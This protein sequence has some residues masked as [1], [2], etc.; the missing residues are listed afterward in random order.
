M[1]KPGFNKNTKE[2]SMNTGEKIKETT[3]KVTRS[4]TFKL[5]AI[6][7]LILLLLIPAYMVK[8]LIR[9]RESRQYEVIREITGK[10]GQEQTITGPVITVPYLIYYKDK[11]GKTISSTRYFHLLPDKVDIKSRI[12]PEVR[13]RSIYEAVLYNTKL[14]ITG[15]FPR[16]PLGKL[17][18]ASD[19]VVWSGASISLG[20]TDMIGIKEGIKAD[21]SGQTLDMAPGLET[22]DLFESGVSSNIRIDKN[23]QSFPFKFVINLNGSSRIRFAPV[24][25]ITTASVTSSWKDPSFDGAFLPV[26]REISDKGFTANWKVLHLNRSYPQCW[27]GKGPSLWESTF[28][29]KLYKP[30]DIYQKSTRMA[31]YALL[32]IVFT[33]MAFFISEIINK[34]RVHPVQYILIGLSILIFY[35]L[36]LSFSEHIGFG[37]AY[38]ISATAIVTMV[39]GY[40]QSVLKNRKVAVMVGGLLAI[41]YTYLYILLQLKDYALL[42]GSIG[43]LAVMASIMYMTRR[44]DWYRVGK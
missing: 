5:M 24:G 27:K 2:S 28:G 41:L 12:T 16:P 33:F 18:I 3:Q 6:C 13:Y 7:S 11:D 10:W 30:V 29:V 42:M 26:E 39:T 31:K 9:E 21:F 35:T 44:I 22:K 8:E 14:E 23:K 37:L 38:L 1:D 15:T 36:L 17:R 32:F 40:A 19:R 25:K 43:L 34:I 4:A 20:L